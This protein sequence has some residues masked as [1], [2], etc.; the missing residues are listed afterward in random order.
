MITYSALEVI[1]TA[2]DLEQLAKVTADYLE[3]FME[4]FFKKTALTDIDDFMTVMVRDVF[5]KGEPVIAE[6]QSNGIFDADSI[7]V[8]VTKE[9]DNLIGDAISRDAYLD[10]LSKLP[11]TNPFR[12]ATVIA[13]TETDGTE[14][15]LGGGEGSSTGT[16][17]SFVTG[18][19]AAAA[20]GVLVLAA[21]LAILKRGNRSFDDED[22]QSLTPRK[23][24]SEDLTTAADSFG[25][26]SFSHWKASRS[27]SDV[28]EF[29]DE[30]L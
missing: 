13:F 20:A 9:M 12:D 27:Y 24:Q 19:V 23:L 25:D 16:G 3:D 10:A 4:D 30:P 29:Q 14:T 15:T 6:Y 8:P 7:F 28:G 21:S 22:I 18:G 2:K 1:P 26:A 17:S 11:K 5:V